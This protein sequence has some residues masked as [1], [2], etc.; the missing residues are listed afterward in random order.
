MSQDFVCYLLLM[1]GMSVIALGIVFFIRYKGKN[2]KGKYTEAAMKFL[3]KQYPTIDLNHIHCVESHL[4]GSLG[5][6]TP[7]LLAYNADDM[8][9]IPVL[10]FPFPGLQKIRVCEETDHEMAYFPMT[11]IE[12]AGFDEQAQKFI[13]A[14]KGQSITLKLKRKNGFM[15]DQQEEVNHFLTTIAQVLEKNKALNV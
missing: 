2:S 12:Q 11:S 4:P 5:R 1:V 9:M 3:A 15:E 14:V 10:P 7:M 6:A 8:Y 13:F